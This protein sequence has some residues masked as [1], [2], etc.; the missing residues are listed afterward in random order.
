M[1][2]LNKYIGLDSVK[3]EDFGKI[4]MGKGLSWTDYPVYE[5]P[6]EIIDWGNYCLDFRI[7]HR[8]VEED[9]LFDL[10]K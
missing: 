10:A 2:L 1:A 6:T 8:F 4:R 7:L 5:V 3:P 9:M